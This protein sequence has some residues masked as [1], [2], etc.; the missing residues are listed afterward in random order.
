VEKGGEMRARGGKA[1]GIG[2]WVDWQGEEEDGARG[3]KKLR[4]VEV[5]LVRCSTSR[6]RQVL[7]DRTASAAVAAEEAAAACE[8]KGQGEGEGEARMGG[9]GTGGHAKISP[10]P[11][12]LRIAIGSPMANKASGGGGACF[13]AAEIGSENP[14]DISTSARST[15]PCLGVAVVEGASGGTS[16]GGDCF[17]VR[18][19]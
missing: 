9:R 13:S 6:I 12:S 19:E 16:V 17:G 18:R 3:R 15:A 14:C 7:A 8:H 2:Q 1:P 5:P 4:C 10:S 11:Q